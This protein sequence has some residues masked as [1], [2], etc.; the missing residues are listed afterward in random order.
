MVDKFAYGAR[1]IWF[2]RQK[3][4]HLWI[5]RVVLNFNAGGDKRVFVGRQPR[6][7]NLA[8]VVGFNGLRYVSKPVFAFCA[9]ILRVEFAI[10]FSF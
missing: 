5:K 7:G 9:S 8:I 1:S 4:G 2:A 10:W 6:A 3:F